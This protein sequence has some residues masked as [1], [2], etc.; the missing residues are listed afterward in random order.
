MSDHKIYGFDVSQ[1]ELNEA[2][3]KAAQYSNSKF[4]V[5]SLGKL[6]SIFYNSIHK[7]RNEYTHCDSI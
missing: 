1:E 3:L 4:S 2:V 5:Y 7:G 6:M